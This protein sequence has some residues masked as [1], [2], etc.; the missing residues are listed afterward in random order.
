M[1]TL[2]QYAPYKKGLKKLSKSGNKVALRTLSAVIDSLGSGTPLPP[3]VNLHALH[4]PQR[5]LMSVW[6]QGTQWVLV[7]QDTPNTVELL[8]LGS[9]KECYKTT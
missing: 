9:H 7:F 6:L 4:G 2:N 1:K 3:T 8:C 5:H